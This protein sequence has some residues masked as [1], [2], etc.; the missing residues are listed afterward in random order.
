MFD[1]KTFAVG[2]PPPSAIVSMIHDEAFAKATVP[3]FDEITLG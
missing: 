2:T 3:E 1:G